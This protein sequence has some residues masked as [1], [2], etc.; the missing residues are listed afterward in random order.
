M[1]NKNVYVIMLSTGSYDSYQTKPVGV[2]FD[3]AKGLK[4]V[5]EKNV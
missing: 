2:I 5:G 3:E 4:Y 1:E